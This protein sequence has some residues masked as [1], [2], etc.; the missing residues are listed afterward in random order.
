MN[1]HDEHLEGQEIF[2]EKEINIYCSRATYHLP[3]KSPIDSWINIVIIMVSEFLTFG[4]RDHV[5][6]IAQMRPTFQLQVE[7][8]MPL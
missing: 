3:L 4:Y 1:I 7:L 8:L 5:L 2:S 6:L